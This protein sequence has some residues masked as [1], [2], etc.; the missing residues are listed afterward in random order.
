MPATT[1]WDWSTGYTHRA[2]RLHLTVLWRIENAL[3]QDHSLIRWYPMP[4]RQHHLS[5]HFR[6]P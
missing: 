6:I 4:G 2:G 1:L 5:L 3:D